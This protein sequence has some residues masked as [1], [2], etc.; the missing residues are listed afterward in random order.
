MGW[1]KKTASRAMGAFVGVG[2]VGTREA[3]RRLAVCQSGC[4]KFKH[5]DGTC[6]LCGCYM[7]VKVAYRALRT[8][9]GPERNACPLGKW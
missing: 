2:D 6:R 8:T 7:P 9:R 5:R 3:D 4:P 1:F